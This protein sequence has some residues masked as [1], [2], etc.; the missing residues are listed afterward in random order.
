M[1]VKIINYEAIRGEL[2][3]LKSADFSHDLVII[4]E[5]QRI[6]NASSATAQA[7]KA[8]KA[9]QRWALTGTPLENNA[10]DV[11]SIF[12]FLIPGLL[13][14]DDS[15]LHI[16]EAIKP[17]IP[18]SAGRARDF[19]PHSLRWR[20]AL[21]NTLGEIPRSVKSVRWSVDSSGSNRWTTRSSWQS[22]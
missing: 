11:V 22:R 21:V 7:V 3:W 9:K 1:V 13:R 15:P 14:E 20:Q 4:D 16:R 19:R 12:G 6:K 17:Y 10:N 2:D 18:L 5:A 8:L